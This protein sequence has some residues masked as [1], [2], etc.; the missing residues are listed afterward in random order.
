MDNQ[1][2][3]G[4]LD[5]YAD[6]L[7]TRELNL[8]RIRAYRRAAETIALL[9]RPVQQILEMQGRAGL[10]ESP[11]IGRHLSYTIETLV[12]TGEFRTVESESRRVV[13]APEILAG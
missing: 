7:D 4:F 10:Q 2:I 5:R 11:G 13:D 9:D 12:K 6:Q 1:T 8:Y 3:A